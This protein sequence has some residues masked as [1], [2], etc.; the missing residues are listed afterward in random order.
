MVKPYR[1][2]NN[3]TFIKK[4]IDLLHLWQGHLFTSDYCLSRRVDIL[5]GQLATTLNFLWPLH[6]ACYARAPETWPNGRTFRHNELQLPKNALS[7]TTSK[8]R[9]FQTLNCLSFTKKKLAGLKTGGLVGL[10]ATFEGSF[11]MFWRTKIFFK[12]IF[13]NILATAL[14]SYIKWLLKIHFC[15]W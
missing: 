10:W 6:T 7:L 15:P 2:K 5:I 1:Y 12:K 3:I 14:K 9:K 11:S 4:L 8:M 13:K